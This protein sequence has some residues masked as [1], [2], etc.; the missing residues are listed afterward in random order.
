MKYGLWHTEYGEVYYIL[1]SYEEA[2]ELLD[3]IELNEYDIGYYEIVTIDDEL[4]R[5]YTKTEF[6][7]F[8]ED[9]PED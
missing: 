9:F 3:Y 2:K 5:D 8:S 6:D 4:K 7:Y 1:N